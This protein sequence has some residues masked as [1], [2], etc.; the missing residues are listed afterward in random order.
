[1]QASPHSTQVIEQ[2]IP[3]SAKLIP[4][5]PV[6]STN[7]T[8]KP[9]P[10]PHREPAKLFQPINQKVWKANKIST[11]SRKG[12]NA[13]L[14][15]PVRRSRSHS[16]TFAA[17]SRTSWYSIFSGLILFDL[18]FPAHFFRKHLILS[19]FSGLL[20]TLTDKF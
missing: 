7:P 11:N 9:D 17:V 18:I 10:A 2:Q 6:Q 19:I 15:Y 8:N 16:R 3:L 14:I 13:Q 20:L 1:V 12:V 4:I 5:H